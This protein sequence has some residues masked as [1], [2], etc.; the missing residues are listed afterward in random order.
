[1]RKQKTVRLVVVYS[2]ILALLAIPIMGIAYDLEDDN[3]ELYSSGESTSNPGGSPSE[4]NSTPNV[5]D[6]FTEEDS[7]TNPEEEETE[8]SDYEAIMA[9]SIVDAFTFDDIRSAVTTAGTTPTTIRLM[10]PVINTGSGEHITIAFN[11]NITIINGQPDANSRVTI[12]RDQVPGPSFNNGRHFV[13][14]GVLNLGQPAGTGQYNNITLDNLFR[15]TGT[16]PNQGDF[17]SNSVI[18]GGVLVSG[19]NANFNIYHGVILQN[20]HNAN[21]GGAIRV[22]GSGTFNMFGGILQHNV[23]DANRGSVGCG[24]AVSLATNATFTMHDGLIY[25]NTVLFSSAMGATTHGGGVSVRGGSL[26]TMNGG[27]IRDNILGAG[28]TGGGVAV[29]DSGSRFVMNNGTISGNQATVNGGGIRVDANAYFD[30]VAGSISYNRVINP[31][32]NGG[33]IYTGDVTHSNLSI[34]TVGGVDTSNQIRFEGNTSGAHAGSPLLIIMGINEGLTTRPNVRWYNWSNAHTLAT[35]S[36]PDI[37]VHLINNWDINVTIETPYTVLR[38]LTKINGGIGASMNGTAPYMSTTGTQLF[39]FPVIDGR[40]ILDA[41]TRDGYIFSHWTTAGFEGASLIVADIH[42]NTN[43][44]IEGIGGLPEQNVYVTAHWIPVAGVYHT[45]TFNLHGGAGD[46]ANQRVSHGG[47]A[48][49]PSIDPTRAGYDFVGWF[50]VQTGGTAFDFSSPIIGDVTIH[51]RWEREQEAVQ[52]PPN[53]VVTAPRTGDIASTPLHLFALI[54]F[55]VGLLN[56]M[57]VAKR[58]ISK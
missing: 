58:R 9:L 37:S 30:M 57:L 4:N 40:V 12:I 2:I 14:N 54:L 17:T 31:N 6:D 27:T 33:G 50:T 18:R 48:V 25:N 35:T 7:A 5:D 22:Q 56:F 51:A 1:M 34:G 24:G 32:S 43:S 20:N 28:S 3:T 36:V 53:V 16:G 10:A 26:F 38:I 46:I 21:N 19:S 13:V 52:I 39:F 29:M 49:R 15:D 23:G 44:R 45:V 41:G 47:L 11:Q 8:N 55:S 42:N